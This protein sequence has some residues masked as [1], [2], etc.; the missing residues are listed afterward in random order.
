MTCSKID[1]TVGELYTLEDAKNQCNS[2]SKCVGIYNPGCS[3]QLYLICVGVIY[4][5]FR[6]TSCVFSKS[7]L[8]GEFKILISIFLLNTNY[9]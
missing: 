1:Y 5:E 6:L 4:N 7:K 2:H 9:H 8:N 3:Q